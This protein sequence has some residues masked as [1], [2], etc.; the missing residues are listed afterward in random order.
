MPREAAARLR[1]AETA[2]VSD[3]EPLCRETTIPYRERLGA[4]HFLCLK[5]TQAGL[6]CYV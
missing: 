3:A 2:A 1:V 4:G 6:L 5:V